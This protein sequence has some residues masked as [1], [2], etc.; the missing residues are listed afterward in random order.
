M[1]DL[2]MAFVSDA[3]VDES[4]ALLGRQAAAPA[5]VAVA[6]AAAL[7]RARK[8]K[9]AV[10]H[11][12]TGEKIFMP[13]RLSFIIPC[14]LM[15][16]TLMISAYNPAT[17]V[18]SQV[19]NQS[20]NACHYYANRNASNTQTLRQQ[21]EAY[22]GATAS[23]VGT[24]IGINHL[25]TSKHIEASR[26]ALLRRCMPF[27]AVAAADVLNLGIM[28]RNEYLEGIKVFDEDGRC[29]GQSPRAGAF[30]V[31]ACVAGRVGAAA[32]VLLVP[33]AVVHALETR[34]SLLARMP[35]AR[36]PILMGLIALN[37]QLAVP[38]FFGVCK[39]QAT[40][41]V[42]VLEDL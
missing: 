22:V 1:M 8:I 19:L 10:V 38:I 3:E 30:A 37:I 27:F 21:I 4:V 17:I 16:D 9:N 33:P 34:T 7:D 40:S 24:A 23:S 36:M 32:P 11:P 14:N 25:A 2:R 41:P 13:L 18:A 39:Q 29:V 35:W 12:D 42:S 6:D 31:S 20:Y 15:L 5:G 26:G 28:R